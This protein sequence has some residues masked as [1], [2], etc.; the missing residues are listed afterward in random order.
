MVVGNIYHEPI[1]EVTE[2]GPV[3]AAV[4]PSVI[5]IEIVPKPSFVLNKPIVLIIRDMQFDINL[6][7]VQ[8]VE[9]PTT[10]IIKILL[11]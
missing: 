2:T 4:S 10:S 8:S 9:N 5:F 1:I 7:F 11:L 6:Y 3:A